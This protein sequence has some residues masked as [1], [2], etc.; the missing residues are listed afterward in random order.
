M[1]AW[2]SKQPVLAYVPDRNGPPEIWVQ[3]Q[4]QNDRP[5]VTARDFPPETTQWFMNPT[6]SPDASRVIYTRIERAGGERLWMSA[7][8]G[9][10]PVRVV[11]NDAERD[12]SGSWSPDGLWFVFL[13]SKGGKESLKKV[14]TNGLADSETLVASVQPPPTAQYAPL[15][16]WSPKGDWILY[17]DGA[18]KLVAPNGK[19]PPRDLGPG[20]KNAICTFSGD[21]ALLYCVRQTKPSQGGP[22]QLLSVNL[23]GKGE[24]IIGFIPA[25]GVPSSYFSPS[26][27][28]SLAPDGKSVA[29]ATYKYSANLWLI[30]GLGGARRSN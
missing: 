15:P 9:G 16:V 7:M 28:L 12:F 3:Q 26:L 21:G 30:D 1:P 19:T 14:K 20:L 23:E 25:E 6:P 5:V 10:S 11:K 18:S 27:R 29:F 24:H 17:S 8:S 22:W 4:G 2:A 13:S